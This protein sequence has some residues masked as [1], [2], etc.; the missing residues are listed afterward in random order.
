MST[1]PAPSTVPNAAR[2]CNVGVCWHVLQ[3]LDPR[4]K[5]N[6]LAVGAKKSYEVRG[7]SVRSSDND[8][9]QL[10]RP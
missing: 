6:H 5:T 10:A 8:A 2:R 3:S 1:L 9:R 7:R 4:E